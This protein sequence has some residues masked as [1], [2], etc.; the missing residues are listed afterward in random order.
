MTRICITGEP[1]DYEG[2]PALRML[3]AAYFTAKTADRPQHD[4]DD[5]REAICLAQGWEF[6]R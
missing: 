4:I 6:K 2:R 3:E 1:T 5:L